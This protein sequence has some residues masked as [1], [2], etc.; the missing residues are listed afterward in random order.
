M[1]MNSSTK[2]TQEV[3]SY[4]GGWDNSS[5]DHVFFCTCQKK[6]KKKKKRSLDLQHP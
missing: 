4:C 3:V 2:Q 1:R 6:K 5:V